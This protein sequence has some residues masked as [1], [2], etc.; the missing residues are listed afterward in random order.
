MLGSA[1]ILLMNFGW[2][3]SE[4]GSVSSKSTLSVV[5]KNVFC[6]VVCTLSFYCFGYGF[7]RNAYGG[8]IGTETFF[9]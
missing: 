7:S 2:M 4:V 8:F 3:L 6:L 1:L 5:S 9:C